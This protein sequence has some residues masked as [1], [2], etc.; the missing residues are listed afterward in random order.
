MFEFNAYKLI[1]DILAVH[2]F[3]LPVQVDR[4]TLWRWRERG[5][6]PPEHFLLA[7]YYGLAVVRVHGLDCIDLGAALCGAG[8]DIKGLLQ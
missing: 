1:I 5:R 4:S 7:Y 2:G 6:V 3:N 8:Y